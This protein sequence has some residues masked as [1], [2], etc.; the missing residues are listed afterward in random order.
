MKLHYT[1]KDYSF[2]LR[3]GSG[4]F[5]DL[6][7]LLAIA[8]FRLFNEISLKVVYLKKEEL[9]R[10]VI[11]AGLVVLGFVVTTYVG[12]KSEETIGLWVSS[13][14]WSV[15]FVT[16]VCL[17][18]LLVF[19]KVYDFQLWRQAD[20]IAQ[21]TKSRST[22]RRKVQRWAD[23]TSKVDQE[24]EME[25]SSDFMPAFDS[26]DWDDGSAEEEE[27][28]SPETLQTSEKFHNKVEEAEEEV[29]FVG[30]KTAVDWSQAQLKELTKTDFT[31]TTTTGNSLYSQSD[32]DSLD[33]EME[34]SVKTNRYVPKELIKLLLSYA[35]SDSFGV[36]ELVGVS[37]LPTGYNLFE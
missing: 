1:E 27:T 20:Y 5:F 32:L 15:Q 2:D 8:P 3:S 16:L 29:K 31:K 23:S 18:L 35:S 22:Q 26:E 17:G 19:V 6:L 11:G 4:L 9:E 13:C 33:I 28:L 34:N 37:A 30:V 24:V 7:M 21:F 14:P 36:E 10:L 25:D 12:M